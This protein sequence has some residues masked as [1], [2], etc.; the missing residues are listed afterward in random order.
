MLLFQFHLIPQSPPPTSTTGLLSC[1]AGNICEVCV[2]PVGTLQKRNLWLS[3]R[4]PSSIAGMWW[5]RVTQTQGTFVLYLLPF[6]C[7]APR[8][9]AGHASGLSRERNRI[10]RV[11]IKMCTLF[12]IES[13][14]FLCD[15]SSSRSP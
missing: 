10:G 8:T 7:S 14:I 15:S 11:V 13:D 6:R 4:G 3:W 1:I 5:E 12:S 9:E 2:C